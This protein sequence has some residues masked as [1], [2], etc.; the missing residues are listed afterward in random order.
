[1]DRSIGQLAGD[2]AEE[3]T[4]IAH[5]RPAAH[6]QL[7]FDRYSVVPAKSSVS[8]VSSTNTVSGDKQNIVLCMYIDGY[9]L[10]QLL[11]FVDGL[12]ALVRHKW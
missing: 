6:W 11:I 3:T 4:R 9:V 8:T 5:I 7:R 1:M 12:V 2:V 10:D